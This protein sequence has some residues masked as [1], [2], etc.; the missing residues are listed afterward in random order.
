[1]SMFNIDNYI[2]KSLAD[3]GYACCH[4][5]GNGPVADLEEKLRALYGARYV[6]CVDNATNGLMYLLMAA[7]LK[8]S[9]E[10]MTSE[11]SFGGTI[12]GAYA[13]GCTFGFVDVDESLGISPAAV[14][15]LLPHQPMVK[16][17]LAVDY[18]GIPHQ[19]EAIHKICKQ[20]GI[21]HFTDAAQS[22][23]AIIDEGRIMAFN[24]AIVLSFGGGKAVYSGGEGGAIITD[25]AML[26]ER[27]L[28]VCQHAHRQE[29]DLGIGKSNQFALNGRMHPIAALLA[30]ESFESGL[31]AIQKRREAC[32]SALNVIHGFKS[33]TT[34]INQQNSSFYH[35]C[36]VVDDKEMFA[37]EFASSGLATDFF[38]EDARLV[39]IPDQLVAANMYRRIKATYCHNLGNLDIYYKL[40]YL[41][42]KQTH[43]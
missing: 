6:L 19:M 22:M 18:A 32:L 26:Y 7:G 1:M 10:I 20:R 31:A 36:V 5:A 21:W 17:V 33:V 39:P 9:D 40:H 14:A 41:N 25:N 11:V 16:A 34:R 28:H 35:C 43:D 37:D 30:C 27:L 24:D 4:W 12:A 2:Q 15:D 29:R 8:R 3:T 23:G 13:L 42:I 38:Y